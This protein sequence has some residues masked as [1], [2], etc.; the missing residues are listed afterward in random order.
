MEQNAR[1]ES[2]RQF[3]DRRFAIEEA[4]AP[5]DPRRTARKYYEAAQAG[6]AAYRAAVRVPPGTRVL[7]YGCGVGS[8]SFDLA[9]AGAN[10]TAIDISPV[11]LRLAAQEAARRGLMIEFREMNAE[12]LDFPDATFDLVCGSAIVHHLDLDRAVPEIAR[13]L[14]PGGRAVFLEP[15][16]H[17]P[18]INWYRRRTPEMRT[19]DE[20]P[21]LVRDLE[22]MAKPFAAM[23]TQHFELFSLAAAPLLH[24]PGVRR[25]TPL[26]SA[27]DRLLLRFVAPVRRHA[28]TV[29]IE[30]EAPR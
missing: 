15:L 30:L 3:H 29:L 22:Q 19:P 14:R 4:D 27:L 8:E 23:R 28:W 11:A 24:I 20:H 7:E 6:P 1:I 10:V 16:G 26:L 12:V 21:L 5:D 2:E 25:L 18:L 13:V 17:N 9:A